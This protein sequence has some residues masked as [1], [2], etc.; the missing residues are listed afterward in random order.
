MM[1]PRRHFL[2]IALGLFAVGLSPHSLADRQT[3]DTPLIWRQRALLGFGTTLWLK[4]AHADA[5][6]LESALDEAV[7]AI[8]Q[9][10]RQMSLFDPHSA[11][12]RLNRSGFAGGAG[13]GP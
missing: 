9:V 4:A 6:L 1:N 11:L 2:R 5:D 3:N 10:E 8:R 12:S 13:A 7:A